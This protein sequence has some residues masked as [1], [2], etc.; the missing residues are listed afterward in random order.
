MSQQPRNKLFEGLREGDLKGCVDNIF[1]VDQYTSKMGN[2]RDCAVLRFRVN[3]KFPAID[4]MEFLERG[5]GFILDSDISSGEE[6]DSK[7]SVFVE[8]ERTKKLPS[9]IRTILDGLTKL[10]GNDEWKFRF[11]KDSMSRDFTEDGITESVPLTPE[12]YD[13][14]LNENRNQEVNTFFSEGGVEVSVDESMTL[15]FKKP[16]FDSLKLELECIGQYD[17]IMED[18]KGP[19]QID[20]TSTSEIFYLTKYLGNYDINKIGGKFV[21]RKHD[22]AALVNFNK[23]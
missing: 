15:T 9:Q 14:K 16:F 19:Y 23:G 6:R 1:T 4:M 11:Y 5:Y 21:I 2:D 10:T 22:Q 13:M 8:M 12:D 17:K 7:Y 3:D 20:E 18:L